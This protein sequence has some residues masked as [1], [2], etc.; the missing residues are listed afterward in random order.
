[1][2]PNVE[3]FRDIFPEFEEVTKR[4]ADY[5]LAKTMKRVSPNEFGDLY[6]HAVY[7]LLAHTLTLTDPENAPYGAITSEKVGDVSY[8]YGNSMEEGNLSLTKYGQEY[9]ELRKENIVP[10]LI[11]GE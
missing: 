4:R 2:E 6:D 1:M 9:V 8:T 10:F 11:L 3:T 5:F 7:L